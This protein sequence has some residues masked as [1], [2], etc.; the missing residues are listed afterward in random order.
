M[1]K[2]C[3]VYPMSAII[4]D[5]RK[6]R[7]ERMKT[8]K[9]V[10]DS[11]SVKPTLAIIQIGDREDSSA[12]INA[13]ISFAKKI[14]VEV[15][16]VKLSETASQNEIISEIQK[17]NLDKSVNG[18]IVQLPLASGMD[19]LPIIQAID[20][21]KD[22]DGLTSFNAQKFSENVPGAIIPATTRGVSELLEYYSIGLKGK[23]VVVVGRS[24]LVGK[25]LAIFAANSG[26]SVTVCHSKTSILSDQ[27]KRA[28][29][30]IVAIGRPK[31][32]GVDH[33]KEGAVVVDVGI[34]TVKGEKLEDEITGRK[35]V[36]DVDFDSVKNVASAITS[37]PGG[38]GPMTVLALF[39]NLLDLCKQG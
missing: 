13:K 26:A 30:L 24:M 6:V 9:S 1:H 36:G 29:V 27:T 33:V 8:L 7:E 39:E 35:L 19:P 15:R 20:P 25:P 31:L 2:L 17:N 34:N 28:D 11:M 3:Y 32:I 10:V 38:V 23:N 5:G 14:G 4:L 16:H 18:I 37:V 22:C 12:Y 21:K